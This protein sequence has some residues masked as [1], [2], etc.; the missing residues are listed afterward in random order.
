[1]SSRRPALEP[2]LRFY[3]ISFRVTDKDDRHLMLLVNASLERVQ[4]HHQVNIAPDLVD[5]PF[6]PGPD[7]RGDILNRLDTTT[8][9]HAGEHDIE[10]IEVD[11]YEAVSP[12]VEHTVPHPVQNPDQFRQAL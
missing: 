1:M 3:F 5:T 2:R 11:A 10:E 8:F 4:S 6:A 9:Q 12:G 7:C